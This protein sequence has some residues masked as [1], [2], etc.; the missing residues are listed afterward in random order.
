MP[1]KDGPS[2]H[3]SG[4]FAQVAQLR[5]DVDAHTD[6]LDDIDARLD[7]HDEDIAAAEEEVRLLTELCASGAKRRLR[8]LKLRRDRLLKRRGK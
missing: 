7:E 3:G 6:R 5:V 8:L 1:K 4:I 2:G